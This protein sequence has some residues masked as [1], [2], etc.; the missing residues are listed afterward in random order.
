MGCFTY[1]CLFYFQII[2]RPFRTNNEER[3]TYKKTHAYL[4]KVAHGITIFDYKHIIAK[5]DLQKSKAVL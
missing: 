5:T 1:K 3:R 4:L 2:F